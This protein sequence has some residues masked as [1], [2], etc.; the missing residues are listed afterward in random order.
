MAAEC[1]IETIMNVRAVKVL[2]RVPQVCLRFPLRAFYLHRIT[3]ITPRAT[4]V[5]MPC[6]DVL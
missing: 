3:Q 1:A 5:F 6:C 2:A 4:V